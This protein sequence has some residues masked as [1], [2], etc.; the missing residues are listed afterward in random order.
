M[1]SS[2]KV[3]GKSKIEIPF[4]LSHYVTCQFLQPHNFTTLTSRAAFH[5]TCQSL[6]TVISYW[7]PCIWL[8]ESKFVSEKHW[9]NTWWNAPQMKHF[10]QKAFFCPKEIILSWNF[11]GRYQYYIWDN[12]ECAISRTCPDLNFRPYCYTNV[13]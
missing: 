8:A 7:N 12:F 6:T 13:S 2:F 11:W 9:Q 3:V 10:L 5:E 4:L 1:G